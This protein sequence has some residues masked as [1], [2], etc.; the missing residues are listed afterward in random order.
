MSTCMAR[1]KWARVW[2]RQ[3]TTTE[4][5]SFTFFPREN[6]LK[7]VA[8]CGPSRTWFYTNWRDSH[9][10]PST[11]SLAFQV[12]WCSCISFI[13]SPPTNYPVSQT[14]FYL[15]LS[16]QRRGSYNRKTRK[17]R[18]GKV[19]KGKRKSSFGCCWTSGTCAITLTWLK[20]RNQSS[21]KHGLLGMSRPRADSLSRFDKREGPREKRKKEMQP[22]E[23]PRWPDWH[24][25]DEGEKKEPLWYA[26]EL[27]AVSHWS[28]IYY[29]CGW[30]EYRSSTF[31]FMM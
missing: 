13:N 15:N 29:L 31:S 3:K 8:S 21:I 7:S 22:R 16:E 19:N 26:S 10:G 12:S 14:M 27:W 23:K 24:S 28:Y 5:S 11:V 2:G 9:S 6:Y 17:R 4:E 25:R 30:K 18:K 20:C 1:C